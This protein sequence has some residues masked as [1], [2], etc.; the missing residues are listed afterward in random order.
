MALSP[1]VPQQVREGIKAAEKGLKD[2]TSEIEKA[3]LAGIDV[4]DQQKE[5]EEL[6]KHARQLKS[7]YG[8]K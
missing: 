7:V 8:S 3:R 1:E 6:K 4:T 5:M 2:L